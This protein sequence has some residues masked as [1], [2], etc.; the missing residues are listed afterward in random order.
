MKHTI[1]YLGTLA[2]LAG[3][4]EAKAAEQEKLT[5]EKATVFLS[6]AQLTSSAKVNLHKGEN[7]ILFSNVAGNINTESIVI[8]IGNGVAVTSTT[9]QNNFLGQENVSPKVKALK[10]SIEAVNNQRKPL[11]NKLSVVTEQISI[12][13]SNKKVAGEDNGLSVAE[14][15][16]MLD[17][18]GTKMEQYLNTKATYEQQIAKID[19]KIT[20]LK[21]QLDE[22]QRNMYQ[23]GGQLLVKFYAPEAT[24]APVSIKYVVPSAGWS[25]IYD[26]WADDASKP[27]RLYYK[28]NVYQNSGVKWDNVRLTLS[29]GNPQ[30]NMQSPELS[31]WYLSFYQNTPRAGLV[32]SMA[33]SA[34]AEDLYMA[35]PM[36]KAVYDSNNQASISN[37][38]T[39]D[40][41]GVN[42]EFDIDLSYSI[43]SDGQQHLVAIKKYEVPASYQYFIV[44][45]MDKDA[46]LQAKVTSWQ[47]LNLLPGQTNIFY[48]GTYVGQG[49]VDPNSVT[50]TLT[51]SLGRDKKVVVKRERDV[52]LRSVKTIG[53]NV[54]ETFVYNISVRNTRKEAINVV[55]QDQLPVSN[56]KD[57]EVNDTEYS[58]ATLEP[59]TGKLTWNMTINGNETKKQALSY[60][61]KYPKGKVV[62]GLR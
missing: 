39:T 13:Q 33:V 49:Y 15:Q 50:D 40:N 31:P 54:K 5:I 29:T 45:K 18:V 38:V 30:E 43:V 59:T 19:E 17:L 35:A 55:M 10:D 11:A 34:T 41:S 32:K 4:I 23:P 12:L 9:F 20:K 53:S 1:I 16:K 42:T 56:D 47:D 52:K 28:A 3:T 57:I 51:F 46:F 7:E 2:I 58:G 37:Y 60:T 6:S 62:S 21:Q 8:N 48:E 44:P 25:P 26:V 61:I 14:L 24:A 22:E 27:I 36:A